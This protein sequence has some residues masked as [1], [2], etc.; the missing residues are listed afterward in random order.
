MSE[1]WFED[2]A[3]G[4][5]FSS[6]SRTLTEAHFLAFAG[7]TGDVHPIHYDVEYA[8]AGP[9]GKRVTHGLLL[10][11]LTALGG[12]ELSHSLSGSMLGFLEQRTR[13]VAPALIGDTVQPWFEVAT[14][15]P[16][17]HQRGLLRLT[18]TVVRSDG[19]TLLEGEHAYLLKGRDWA[20]NA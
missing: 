6:P 3:V 14:C 4:E 19:T 15:E 11:S 7:L 10:A 1:R 13:F 12:S 8:A 9:F 2:F 20:P 16:R 18:T 17:S 5:R